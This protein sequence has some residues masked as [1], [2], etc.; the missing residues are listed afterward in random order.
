MC[1]TTH[2]YIL[3]NRRN[4]KKVK[5]PSCGQKTF[6]NYLDTQTNE[7]LPEYGRCDRENSCGTH[8]RP[9]GGKNRPKKR[10]KVQ[11]ETPTLL[12]VPNEQERAVFG[13]LSSNFH[14]WAN[15]K[16][17]ITPA[18]FQKWLVGTDR[19][20]ATTFGLAN[21]Q[22]R[23]IKKIKYKQNG[24]RDKEAKFSVSA[25]TR[26]GYRF[27]TCLYGA[28]LFSPE[29][30]TFITESE[31]SA[32][33]CSFLFPQFNFL[34]TGGSKGISK[35][36]A[37]RKL[38]FLSQA[39]GR[40]VILGDNDKAGRESDFPSK[41]RS[42][43]IKSFYHITEYP[44][45]EKDSGDDI[46]DIL[47][48]FSSFDLEAF[49]NDHV[50]RIEKRRKE[51]KKRS[52]VAY[53]N[54]F[55][56]KEDVSYT[57][58]QTD[59][60]LK[61][62]SMPARAILNLLERGNKRVALDMGTGGGKTTFCLD[63]SKANTLA[64]LAS[65]ER[66]VIFVTPYSSHVESFRH[67]GNDIAAI[68]GEC[69]KE[70]YAK[71]QHAT[72]IVVTADSLGK[73]WHRFKNAYLVIDEVHHMI[74]DCE[75][76]FRFNAFAQ[77][78]ELLHN[79][80]KYGMSILI[81]SATLPPEFSKWGFSFIKVDQETKQ[82]KHLFPV[83]CEG[84]HI[85]AFLKK[86][87]EISE[88]NPASKHLILHD[89]S[90]HLETIV[91]E[92]YNKGLASSGQD[93]VSVSSE[94]K[95]RNQPYQVLLKTHRLPENIKFFLATQLVFDGIDIQN[96]DNFIVHIIDVFDETKITQFPAR[97]RKQES[98][99]AYWYYKPAQSKLSEEAY[100]QIH[101][102]SDTFVKAMIENA[103]R[104]IELSEEYRERS[105]IDPT[106]QTQAALKEKE[107]LSRENPLYHIREGIDT[108]LQIVEASIW[109]TAYK[110][111]ERFFRHYPFQ[112]LNWM[113]NE[114]GFIVHK[115]S[116]SFSEESEEISQKQIVSREEKK[117]AELKLREMLIEDTKLTLNI[118]YH[119]AE[120][121]K[122][123][124]RLKDHRLIDHMLFED[125]QKAIQE[126]QEVLEKASYECII[127]YLRLENLGIDE[128]MTLNVLRDPQTHSPRGFNRFLAK[129][130]RAY[131]NRKNVEFPSLKDAM[132]I[133]QCQQIRK[134][135]KAKHRSNRG[136][137]AAEEYQEII[138]S[139][140]G[141]ELEKSQEYSISLMFEMKEI[142]VQK[143]GKKGDKK[144]RKYSHLTEINCES[145]FR[146]YEGDYKRFMNARRDFSGNQVNCLSQSL[147]VKSIPK[148]LQSSG[149]KKLENPT[150]FPVKKA[151]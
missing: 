53:R 29:K 48:R 103:S 38:K 60:Y 146:Q 15:F 126:H 24:H 129:F 61:G 65:K 56:T 102:S 28:H 114:R 25:L 11:K 89:N 128:V 44:L 123:R 47:E 104:T 108:N 30:D 135:V 26:K 19:F 1:K 134:K 87:S 5:C 101:T 113:E 35:S 21:D 63:E 3:D 120:R 16:F 71:A 132:V 115:Q 90:D 76:G 52:E 7:L 138:R 148:N 62:G 73:I 139:V 88:K 96:E 99:K 80:E 110:M 131:Y 6:T 59:K 78:E 121:D 9:G 32:V 133:S 147:R 46:A 107:K 55:R 83:K 122:I 64:A 109:H 22:L 33:I 151:S 40:I 34:A 74:L 43:G 51:E 92:L 137:I 130:K 111:K 2:R 125:V 31:K 141:T 97:P 149:Q 142:R 94:T 49:F 116:F 58:F 140:V 50:H 20:R 10:V 106:T 136:K 86:L 100:Q 98:V 75:R 4:K 105:Q 36:D 23:H 145:I 13:D 81:M 45:S 84:N 14:Q 143:K 68:W 41:L 79:Q 72:R 93:A 57:T 144:R 91:E 124:E 82:E 8:I 112:L 67:K 12:S 85:A 127:Q 42:A 66:P 77:L 54:L 118:A 117:S 119:S 70:D 39:K 95:E 37:P 27:D 17:C 150:L 18:H 69:T